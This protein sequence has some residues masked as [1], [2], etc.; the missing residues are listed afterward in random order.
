MAES[1]IKCPSCGHQF[2]PSQALRHD[3]ESELSKKFSAQLVESKKD[4]WAKAQEAAAKQAAEQG[5][6]E[7][8]A[9]TQELDE[10]RKQADAYQKDLLE[11][12]KRERALEDREKLREVENAKKLAEERRT[13]AEESDKRQASILEEKLKQ[14]QDEDRKRL[15][16]KDQQMAILQKT[17]ADL[18]RQ[19]VQGSQQ[20]QGDA[21]E[22][23]FKDQLARAFPLDLIE[24]VAT[25]ENGADLLQTVR[26]GL[27]RS[28]GTI[29][30][31]MKNTKS[32]S[33]KWLGK[34]KDDRARA[35]ADVAVL[36]TS[37]LPKGVRHFGEVDGL[38]VT[39]PAYAQMVG[40]LLRSGL[41][42]VAETRVTNVG[43]ESKMEALYVYLSSPQFKGRIESVMDAF[44]AMKNDI[45]AEKRAAVK[46]WALREKSLDR[47]LEGVGGMHGELKA[48]MGSALPDVA[49][50]ELPDRGQEAA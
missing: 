2:E 27:G 41:L 32:W 33:E 14:A 6:L 48:L 8:K 46:H 20:A 5:A 25:G 1:L 47:V 44:T 7:K 17:I 4:L 26:D 11:A 36:V 22:N 39:E 21:L 37:A 42:S 50:L 13:M 23:A 16:D 3:L 49:A 43:R 9:I 10:K 45:D 31:E 28:C 34:L 30:W 15:A 38:W 24:D 19:A 40:A 29:V 18:Q 35:K 12:M